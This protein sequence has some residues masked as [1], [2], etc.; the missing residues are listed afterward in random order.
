MKKACIIVL[1]SA[2]FLKGTTQVRTVTGKVLDEK[3][4]PVA[5]ASIQA[6]HTQIATLSGSDGS[7]SIQLPAGA[8]TIIVSYVGYFTKEIQA[9][10]ALNIDLQLK[11]G[12]L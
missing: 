8:D 11:E 2:T 1:L 12:S 3:R 4:S 9:A 5:G 10:N 7:F 6:K